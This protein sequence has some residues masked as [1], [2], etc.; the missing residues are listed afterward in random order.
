[1]FP[2]VPY[3]SAAES[4]GWTPF[5]ELHAGCVL[6][7][8]WKAV[9]VVKLLLDTSRMAF[10]VTRG[11]MEKTDQNGA[12]KF[13]RNTR[14][15]LWTVQVMALDDTGGEVLLV[16]VAG[17]PPKVTVGQQV[18]PVELEAI[19]WNTN[20]K[21]GTAFRAKSLNAMPAGKAA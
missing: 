15:P 8:D 14:E 3:L 6:V 5:L 1:M 4:A 11:A 18:V 7:L 21:N 20:G 17:V 10:T 19:P 2:S 16:T 9:M 12:Q 13:D